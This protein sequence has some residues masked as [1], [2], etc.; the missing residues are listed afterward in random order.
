[1]DQFIQQMPYDYLGKRTI[2]LDDDKIIIDS[3][4]M[5]RTLSD[6]YPYAKIDPEFKTIRRGEKEW[7]SIVYG[8]IVSAVVL[9]LLLKVSN[10]MMFKV[11]VLCI[12]LCTIATATYLLSLGY[13]KRNF[14]FVLDIE[15]NC[16]FSLKETDKSKEFIKKL[17]ERIEKSKTISVPQ[18]P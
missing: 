5:L 13:F 8:L 1:M 9:F 7:G 11:I 16:V 18:K 15:G 17:K 10:N 3:K 14:V 4:N 2:K 6:D 12:Q